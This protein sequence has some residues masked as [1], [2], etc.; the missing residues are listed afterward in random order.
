MCYN[1]RNVKVTVTSRGGN[2][3]DSKS[4]DGVFSLTCDGCIVEYCLD[5]DKCV[6]TVKKDAVTQERRG[7]QNVF[8]TFERGKTTQCTIGSGG[9]SGGFEIFTRNIEILYGKGGFKVSLEY[10]SGSDKEIINL[11]LVA[12]Y[13]NN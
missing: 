3:S 9:L 10:E 5:G 4:S 8:I 7:A 6:L 1:N 11:S 13:K 12:V 2:W